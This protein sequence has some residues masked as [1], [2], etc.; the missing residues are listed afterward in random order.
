M[1]LVLILL[2]GLLG[3]V[4]LVRWLEPRL[5]FFPSPGE[6]TTP[7]DFGAAYAATTIATS[8][9][10]RLRVWLLRAPAPRALI[11]YFHGN[12]GNLSM[13]APILADV[14]HRGYDVLAFDY[15]GYGE[16]SGKPSETRLYRD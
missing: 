1:R 7:H 11:V 6:T 2:V 9:G 16:S 10:G 13:W 14:A 8:D 4:V 15:R 5:A 12:G 3:L